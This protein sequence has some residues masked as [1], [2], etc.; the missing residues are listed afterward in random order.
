MPKETKKTYE[1]KL[2]IKKRHR[3]SREQKLKWWG[4]GEW[5]EESD[6]A[7][8]Q[9]K[10]YQCKI[11]RIFIFP[12]IDACLGGHLSGYVLIPTE[13]PWHGKD[14]NTIKCLVH[15][16]LTY[17]SETSKKFWIGFDCAHWLDVIPATVSIDRHI[18]EKT[19]KEVPGIEKFYS[20]LKETYKNMSFCVEECKNI[21]NQA[22]EAAPNI[23]NR[24]RM[25]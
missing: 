2:D 10:G 7:T 24:E 15:G 12:S 13:H 20:E 3:V 22:I 8:F 16:G 6:I 14:Y 23:T 9:Y 5:V 25:G 18:R 19:K 11:V 17:A 4:C 21:V 1:K